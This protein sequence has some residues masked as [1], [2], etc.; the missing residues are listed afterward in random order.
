MNFALPAY[1]RALRSHWR[2]IVWGLIVALV[3]A[4]AV[5]LVRPPLYRSQ[6]TVFV[7]TPGDVSRVI[8]GGDSYAQ[9][10]AMTY[11]VL[12]SSTA[13]SGRVVADL[14][15]S[16]DPETLSQRIR[17]ENPRGTA[18]IRI[19]VSAP[20]ADEA[21]RIA[22]VFLSELATTVRTLESVPGSL[23]PR[24]ELV[25]VDPPGKPVLDAGWGAP[26]PVFLL[27]AALFGL[28][29]GATGAVLR[30]IFIA[31]GNETARTEAHFDE[32]DNL[33]AA[34]PDHEAAAMA[35]PT[36]GHESRTVPVRPG[37]ESGN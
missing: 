27:G 28:V 36:I 23:V 37:N 1:G 5:L 2:W 12:S 33:S 18:L 35:E 16:I 25:V 34:E 4:T 29:L 30:S 17:A 19:A 15:L 13:L 10:R 31:S 24:A 7:R 6:A 9:R 20:T 3:S 26:I 22:T 32:D 8:D 21:R 11:A 14:N